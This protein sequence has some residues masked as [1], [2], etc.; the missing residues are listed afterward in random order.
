MYG[1]Q[2]L[3]SVRYA[4][5]HPASRTTLASDAAPQVV[6]ALRTA[7]VKDLPD[8]KQS[9]S[10]QK[11]S[12]IDANSSTTSHASESCSS[13]SKDRPSLSKQ[14]KSIPVPTAPKS[15]T[16]PE[17]ESP[18]PKVRKSV[19]F[20]EGTKDEAPTTLNS[21]NSRGVPPSNGSRVETIDPDSKAFMPHI[22]ADESPE[23][24][25]LRREM[26]RYSLN[27]VGAVVA[28]MNLD[29]DSDF[30]DDRSIRSSS[31]SDENEDRFGRSQNRVLSDEYVKEMRALEK[32]LNATSLENIGPDGMVQT[33]LQAE[34]NLA[35]QSSGGQIKS[36]HL[37]AG[38]DWDKRKVHSDKALDGQRRP[39]E[40][41]ETLQG[42]DHSVKARR[43]VH[44]NIVERLAPARS[45]V[46]ANTAPAPGKRASR[47]KATRRDGANDAP[48]VAH[49][50]STTPPTGHDAISEM[51]NT[52]RNAAVLTPNGASNKASSAG[53]SG[54]AG[55]THAGQVVEHPWTGE[56]DIAGAPEPDEWGESVMHQELSKEYHRMRKCM[57]PQPTGSVA[58]NE[59]A[60]REQHD[61][62]DEPLVDEQGN[63]IS[64]FK[65]DRLG[66]IG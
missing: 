39:K 44:T 61:E 17:H 53:S 27:E 6:N 34:D 24:A 35:A 37:P 15:P 16:P 48:S 45:V 22:P 8:L 14:N 66:Q 9:E 65:A 26:I 10:L 29:Y 55:R 4:Y 20:A 59:A 3:L 2:C 21:A 52:S 23:D 32:K 12:G 46:E 57:I 28:E 11:A 5:R 36:N 54:P 64:R 42:D 1:V 7:G 19:A 25:A 60:R 62:D 51:R 30:D 40:L 47:F 33:L 56:C 13:S 41:Q 31:D 43:P 58:S 38:G 18:A 50:P 63:R 49:L